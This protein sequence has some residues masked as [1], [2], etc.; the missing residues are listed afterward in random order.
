MAE[1]TEG[2]LADQYKVSPKTMRRNAAY[3]ADINAI[4]AVTNYHGQAVVAQTEGKLGRQE[5]KELAILAKENPEVVTK[6]LHSIGGID[7]P[8]IA[9]S[10]VRQAVKDIEGHGD[11]QDTTITRALEEQKEAMK[12]AIIDAIQ[13]EARS[14]FHRYKRADVEELIMCLQSLLRESA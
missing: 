14:I 1:R 10:I 5:V 4:S 12:R 6:G 13:D 7:R 2:K 9:K 3:A 8:K 11:I